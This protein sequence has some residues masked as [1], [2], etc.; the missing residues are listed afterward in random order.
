[1]TH[2][3]SLWFAVSRKGAF[4]RVF[5]ET[6]KYPGVQVVKSVW[7]RGSFGSKY[8]LTVIRSR[9]WEDLAERRDESRHSLSGDFALRPR[10]D[11]S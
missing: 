10:A 3:T 2:T 1:M 9:D 6:L 4:F 5:D 11:K 8:L 7:R